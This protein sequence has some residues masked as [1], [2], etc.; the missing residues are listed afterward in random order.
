MDGLRHYGFIY[1]PGHRR[2][3]LSHAD[4][5]RPLL[6]DLHILLS[7]VEM[8]PFLAC[9]MCAFN[10]PEDAFREVAYYITDANTIGLIASVASVDWGL[11]VQILAAASIGSDMHFIPTNAQT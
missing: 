5:R 2:A 8:S 3:R 7:E 11:A 6:L 1:C 9:R 4:I 10:S